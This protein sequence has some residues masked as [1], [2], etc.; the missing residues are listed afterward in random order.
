MGGAVRVDDQVASDAD[1]PGLW[2]S[3]LVVVHDLSMLPRPRRGLLC[4]V[5]GPPAI[6]TDQP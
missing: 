1:R 3:R 4:D 2:R 6:T 5:L